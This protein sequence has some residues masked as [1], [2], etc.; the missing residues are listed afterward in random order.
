MEFVWD[1]PG[2]PVPEET[3]GCY[4]KSLINF[5]DATWIEHTIYQCFSFM[6][7]KYLEVVCCRQILGRIWHGFL[8][9]LV[10]DV[11]AQT[12]CVEMFLQCCQWNSERLATLADV[13]Y[14]TSHAKDLQG[15][16][17]TALSRMLVWLLCHSVSVTYISAVFLRCYART[18]TPCCCCCAARYWLHCV[19]VDGRCQD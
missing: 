7:E 15:T 17:G 3:T 8:I 6:S 5:F 14:I 4:K 9:A 2:E 18:N 1:N 12:F 16:Y 13:V 19:L 11:V 10:T